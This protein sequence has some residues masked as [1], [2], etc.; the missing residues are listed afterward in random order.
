MR[1][2]EVFNM[3]QPRSLLTAAVLLAVASTTQ[4][5]SD[6]VHG[7]AGLYLGG[8]TVGGQLSNKVDVDIDDVFDDLNLAFMGDFSIGKGKW[9][10]N[11]DL[12][13][14][15]ADGNESVDINVPSFDLPIGDLDLPI[16]ESVSAKAKGSLKLLVL[17]PTVSYT[18]VDNDQ[19]EFAALGG[20]RYTSADAKIKASA[21]GP[22]VGDQNVDESA[23]GSFWDG[24]VG[25]KG[26]IKL[27]D[28]AYIP[29]YA[30]VGTG[31]SKVTWQVAAGF[32]YQFS[33]FDAIVNYRYL[34]WDFDD[35]SDFNEINIH[36]PF[37]GVRA[38]F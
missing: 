9:A 4:A 15:D 19:I 7:S 10:L 22:F 29:Y 25:A 3:N 30:D 24:V 16:G 20:V 2:Q 32:G 33:N 8:L 13:Y 6:E 23:S 34:G 5:S 28:K 38:R 37:A 36:G 26:R 14:M 11:A 21:S 31:T 1:K 27:T 17:T 12:I 35:R 18:V